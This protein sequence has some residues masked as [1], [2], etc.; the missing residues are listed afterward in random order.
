MFHLTSR[1]LS[2]SIPFFLPAYLMGNWEDSKK[3]K[4]ATEA[5]PDSV[6]FTMFSKCGKLKN[7]LR[8]EKDTSQ[9]V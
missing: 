9:V 2:A 6:T 3:K 8:R 5:K 4:H 7:C 1:Q